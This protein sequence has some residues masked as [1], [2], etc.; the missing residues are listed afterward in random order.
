MEVPH[1]KGSSTHVLELSRALAALGHK[2][3]VISRRGRLSPEVEE[4]GGVTFHRV[5][6]GILRPVR[7]RENSPRGDGSSE[8][9]GLS[10]RAYRL[11]LE[12]CFAFYVAYLARRIIDRYD[13]DM[14]IERET[15]FGAGAL[16]SKMS[17]K[18]MVLEMIGPSYSQ[19]SM[20]QSSRVLAYN[21]LMVPQ[22]A[23]A[24]A[25]F[26]RAAVNLDM[27]KPDEGSRHAVRERLGLH[28]SVTVGYI[29]SFLD[30]HGVD[31]LIEAAEIVRTQSGG[32]RYLMV[33]P[34][35]SAVIRSVE[36]HGLADLVMFVGPVPY[37][38]VPSYINACD[39][40]VAPYN[41]LRTPSRRNK[42]IGSPLKVLEYMACGKP[43]IGSNLPQV[44]DLVE[45]GRTGILFQQGDAGSFA[46]SIMLLAKDA[47]QRER[48]GN[49][50]LAAA[51]SVYSWDALAEQISSII[52]EVAASNG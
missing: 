25:V 36:Q 43:S 18:P 29:G 4:I 34:H 19:L 14:I 49:S 10:A 22:E 44:S 5:Y 31:D 37:D 3:H 33:G 8:A 51:R 16:A 52:K 17:R 1:Y 28:D 47:N 42:G 2:V 26:V 30:W 6:R 12:T 45:D 21:E 48:L 20:K 32:V 46:R 35:T 38:Q 23:M 40:L 39:I 41:I 13:L 24:K 11:Y 50:A 9:G 7:S 27:F 15:A